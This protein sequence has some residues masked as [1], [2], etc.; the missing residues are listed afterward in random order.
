[1]SKRERNPEQTYF[2]RFGEKDRHRESELTGV[3]TNEM[4]LPQE[5]VPKKET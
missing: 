1:M 2:L 4:K 5:L 3:K